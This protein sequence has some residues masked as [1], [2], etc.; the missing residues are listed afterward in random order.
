MRDI[1]FETWFTFILLLLLLALVNPFGLW[2]PK[3]FEMICTVL[4]IVFFV[5]FAVSMLR[6]KTHDEREE[7]HRFI[8]ARFAYFVGAGM[9][10][11]GIVIQTFMHH[12]TFWLPL[13]LGGM[14]VAKSFGRWY[15]E[16]RH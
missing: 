11:L 13:A 12:L 14:L 3:Q 15:A 2:M 16:R 4:V 1:A 5:L 6:E 10:V 7:L 8:A 9:L